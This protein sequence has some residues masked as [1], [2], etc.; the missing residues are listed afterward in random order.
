[1]R[2][3]KV[4]ANEGLYGWHITA[5][6]STVD[7]DGHYERMLIYRGDHNDVTLDEPEWVVVQVLNRVTQ[8]LITTMS[9][10]EAH[11]AVKA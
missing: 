3:V 6:Y 9:T 2:D 1:M 7:E 4:Y 5:T 10:T 11:G 8:D